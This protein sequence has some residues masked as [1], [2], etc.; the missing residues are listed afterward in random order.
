M[1]LKIFVFSIIAF[2]LLLTELD[3]SK[4]EK[5]KKLSKYSTNNI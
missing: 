1:A 5:K 3:F 4:E 2:S